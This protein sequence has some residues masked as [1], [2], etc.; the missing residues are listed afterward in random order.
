MH[1]SKKRWD[2]ISRELKNA[3]TMGSA[4]VKRWNQ[5]ASDLFIVYLREQEAAETNIRRWTAL[6][7]YLQYSLDAKLYSGTL[8]N[9]YQVQ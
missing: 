2:T 5:G 1:A 3:L 8:L 9:N 6:Y 4:E 7:E